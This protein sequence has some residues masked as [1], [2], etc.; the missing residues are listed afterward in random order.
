MF[1]VIV[2]LEE[3]FAPKVELPGWCLE[4]LLQCLYIMFFPHDAIYL[5]KWT[6]PSYSKTPQKH[7]GGA[8]SFRVRIVFSGLQSSLFY[9]TCKFHQTPG[10]VLKIKVFVTVYICK[11]FFCWFWSN[12]F[13][14][15]EWPFSPCCYRM[16]FTVNNETLLPAPA[17]IFTSFL[18]LFW[19]WYAHFP[20]VHLWDSEPVSILSSLMAGHSHDVYTRV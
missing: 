18:L 5:R 9:S 16:N 20:P 4:M 8:P 12:G 3:T 17:S 13:F 10:H 7:D 19:G 11:L 14:L 6:S 2:H 15:A 1:R